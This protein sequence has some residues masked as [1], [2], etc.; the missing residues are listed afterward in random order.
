MTVLQYHVNLDDLHEIRPLANS[1][2]RMARDSA[3]SAS[4]PKVKASGSRGA[5][6][7]T[8]SKV[9]QSH[10][11]VHDLI[12]F[13]DQDDRSSIYKQHKYSYDNTSEYVHL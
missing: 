11:N 10:E 13:L 8:T 7:L 1:N 5:L 2:H 9:V 6:S 4:S 12:P 3:D